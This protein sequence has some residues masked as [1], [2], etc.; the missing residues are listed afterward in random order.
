[1]RRGCADHTVV[2]T[3]PPEALKIATTSHGPPEALDDFVARKVR[4]IGELRQQLVHGVAVI[5]GCDHR[6]KDGGCAIEC[7]GVGPRL[8]RMELGD[9]PRAARGG[10][11]G[12]EPEVDGHADTVESTGK[13]NMRPR[14]R[15]SAASA[16]NQPA[17]TPGGAWTAPAPTSTPSACA[18]AKAK[19]SIERAGSGKRSSAAAPSSD[20]VLSTAY[21]RVR[22]TC[23]G[24]R[25]AAK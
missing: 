9:V 5:Q 16:S 19:A 17:G 3:R 8:E 11:I 21:T 15:R 6:L 2:Q 22:L 10:L 1:L 18:R 14:L 7:P 20:G 12:E 4:L 25:R 13:G 24:R 23:S